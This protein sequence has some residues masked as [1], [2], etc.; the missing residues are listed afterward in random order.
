MGISV[1]VTEEPL[2]WRTLC[3]HRLPVYVYVSRR[4]YW[5]WDGSTYDSVG[6]RQTE[7]GVR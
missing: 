2:I 1:V 7:S 4:Y 6:A 3:L 5:Y